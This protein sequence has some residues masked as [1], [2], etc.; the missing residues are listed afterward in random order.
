MR[1]SNIK[2]YRSYIFRQFVLLPKGHV[3]NYYFMDFTD[4]FGTNTTIKLDK[5]RNLDNQLDDFIDILI[6]IKLNKE[7]YLTNN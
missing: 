5:N 7:I 6:K 4:N 3:K 1:K 2:F